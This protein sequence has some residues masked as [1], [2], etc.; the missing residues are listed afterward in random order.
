MLR[1]KRRDGRKRAG[2]IIR[3]FLLAFTLCHMLSLPALA[4]GN[5]EPQIVERNAIMTAA[6]DLDAKERP[7]ASAKTVISY[8]EG[9]SIFVT[10]ELSDG[11]YRVQYRN[12]IGYVETGKVSALDVDAEKLDEEFRTEEEK[13]I[14]VVEEI[15]RRRAETRRSRIWG[16]VIAVLVIGIFAVSLVSVRRGRKEDL[17]DR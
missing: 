16:T 8:R 13:S 4:Q 15:E 12:I 1:D 2:G 14:P 7:D 3:V 17:N 10:G 6:E 5:G 9:D 11:W